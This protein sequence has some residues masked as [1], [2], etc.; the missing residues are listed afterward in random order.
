MLVDSRCGRLFVQELGEGPPVVL[1]HSVLCDTGMWRGQLP[2]L[3][4]RHRVLSVD[5]PG[6]GRSAP[7]RS[8]YTMDDCVEAALDVL[9]AS[10]VDRCAWV[11]LSWGGM[12]GMRLAARHPERVAAL[13]LM[14]TS[15]H[16]EPRLKKVSYRPLVAISQRLGPVRPLC[17]VVARIMMAPETF[18]QAPARVEGFIQTLMRMD[19][20]SI[21]HV[22]DA[23]VFHR[24]DCTPELSKIRAPTLVVVGEQDGATPVGEAE[25][26]VRQIRGARF[27][28]IPDAGHLSAYEQPERVNAALLAFLQDNLEQ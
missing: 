4:E 10:G 19:P 20:E 7:T 5:G 1:W 27:V 8:A 26:L 15:A 24:D 22:I 2:V 12:V 23:I 17:E 9:E 3:G 18:A 25:H 11:G 28:R 21:A 14:D 13:V 16:A 6:H